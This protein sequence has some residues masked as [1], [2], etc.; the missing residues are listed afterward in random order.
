MAQII[1][2]YLGL[3]ALRQ[4]GYR[5]TATAVAELVDNSIE[6]E[7]NI[8]DIIAISKDVLINSRT[9]S[10]VQKIAVL[11]NGDGMPVDILKNCL[12]LGWGTRLDTR[13][14][15]GRFGFGLKGASISQARRVEVYSWIKKNEVFKAYLDLDE[16]R[17]DRKQV[18]NEIEKADLPKEI[19]QHFSEK[20]HDSGTVVM[21]DD[22]DQ[23]D[24]KRADTLLNRI[25]K[26][27][28]R[29]YRH[30]LD[31]CGKYGKKRQINLHM[32]QY[33][34][35]ACET[36]ILKAND[37]LYQLT[38]N[39]LPG[40]E[41]T[42]TN[43][44]FVETFIVPI[45]YMDGFH[46]KSS[47]VEFRFTIAK[48]E[49]QNISGGSHSPV[50]KHYGQNTGISFVRA[51]REIDFGSFGFL[52][53]SEPRH[54]WWGAEVRFEPVLDELFGVTNNKQEVRAIKKFD[55]EML[56]ILSESKEDG[57]YKANLLYEINK[58]LDQNIKEMMKIITGRREG[59]RKK[60]IESGALIDRVNEDVSKDKTP[61]ESLDHSKSLTEDQKIDERVKLL[62]HDDSSLDEVD[63][64]KIAVK[65]IDYRVDILTDEWPGNLF[66]D[67]RFAA[68]ASVGI[69][70]RNT[71]FYEQFWRYLEEF[72]DKKGY[73]ALEVL[74]IAL[75]RA[76]D[77]LA[78][79]YDKKTFE[80]FREKWG[81]WVERLIS[82]A[83][84]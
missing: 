49:I 51:G 69:I 67:R 34:K 73:E 40:Y 80:N 60:K 7:A 11:D 8:I 38:P 81:M 58:I 20:I 44:S 30:F 77:E 1:D 63:A 45:P 66:L 3:T 75:I 46:E 57:D 54:R 47:N 64:R 19:I 5:S 17:N 84:S 43:E 28:C 10:Q 4:A 41:N 13:E 35:G 32:L 6:A 24:L 65:T 16:I 82:H 29:I 18:L 61:T 48:P 22:L 39:N 83:G 14:G 71:Q 72:E 59:S 68:N 26:E 53:A 2:A 76:E 36:E 78:I 31:D 21:W 27:L 52:D 74:M 79:R 15:L 56:E 62:L 70:N 9:S 50:R 12:S 23:M 55:S 42:A 37:P 33:D 25:N